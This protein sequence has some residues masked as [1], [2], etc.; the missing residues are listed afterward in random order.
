MFASRDKSCSVA[1]VVAPTA[2]VQPVAVR[3][4]ASVMEA[5][6]IAQTRLPLMD[7]T[8][9]AVTIECCDAIKQNNPPKID[10]N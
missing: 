10:R 7:C 6:G 1:M 2:S 8:V 9:W 4:D 3:L 5:P